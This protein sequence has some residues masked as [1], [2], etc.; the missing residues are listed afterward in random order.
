MDTQLNPLPSYRI[1][2]FGT[3][4]SE[5]A[6]MEA[7][8]NEQAKSGYVLADRMTQQAIGGRRQLNVLMHRP[9]GTPAAA[10][11]EGGE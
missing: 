6:R 3:S 9:N 11:P 2:T 4:P 1:E 8:L 10:T 5:V 7:W